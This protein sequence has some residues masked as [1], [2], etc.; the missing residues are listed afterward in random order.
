MNAATHPTNQALRGYGM[1]KLDNY[2]AEAISRHLDVCSDCVQRVAGLSSDSFLER[3]REAELADPKVGSGTM[4]GR[5]DP[6]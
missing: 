6:H 5:G 3:L 2:A 1:G 4:S